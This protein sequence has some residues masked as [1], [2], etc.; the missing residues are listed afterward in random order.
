MNYFIFRFGIDEFFPRNLSLNNIGIVL[1]CLGAIVY[2]FIPVDLA[3]FKNKHSL[4]IDIALHLDNG[5]LIMKRIA[6][7]FLSFVSGLLY[8]ESITPIIYTM[9]EWDKK[10]NKLNDT[11][12]LLDYFFSFY[13]G[14]FI[15]SLTVFVL[16]SIIKRNHPMVQP[17]LVLPGLISGESMIN[18]LE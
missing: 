6:G 15:N 9:Q 4:P 17:Y 18:S 16:Y 13:C 10:Y 14:F 11:Y 2:L 12:K 8:I 7:L 5:T 3:R 1:A